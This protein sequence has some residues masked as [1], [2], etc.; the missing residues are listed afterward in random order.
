MRANLS[1]N[2]A[3]GADI[4]DASQTADWNSGSG[5]VPIGNQSANFKG[6]FEGLGHNITGLKI[7]RSTDYQ[8]GLFGTV[9]NAVIRNINLKD[10][11]ISGRGAVGGL[12]GF[13]QNSLIENSHTSGNIHGN[14][15]VGGLVGYFINGNIIDSSSTANISP[16]GPNTG[17]DMGGLVGTFKNGEIKNSFAKS[18]ISGTSDV[19]GLIG[20][21]VNASINSS[22]AV[23]KMSSDNIGASH[24]GGLLG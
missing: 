12:V 20:W 7:N 13:G 16:L 11:Y 6:V 22:Y 19:G 10:I 9:Q 23:T 2:Y 15:D 18:E 14:R 17:Y 3:L 8:I 1:A 21:G 4:V 24:F 5:F